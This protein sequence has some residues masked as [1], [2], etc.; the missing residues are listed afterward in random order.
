[1]K[2]NNLVFFIFI[3]CLMISIIISPAKFLSAGLNGISAWAFCVLPTVLPFMILSQLLLSTG[4]VE[5]ICK[6]LTTPFRKIYN[7]S[8][9]SPY[10]FLVSIVSGYPIGSKMIADLYEQGKISRTDVYRMS[11]FC[12]NSGPMFIIGAVGC[13]M[14]FSPNA[15]YIILISHILSAILN[16]LIYRKINAKDL[17]E[18]PLRQIDHKH[19]TFADIIEN[20]CKSILNVGTIIAFFFI[21]IEFTNQIIFF[22]PSPIQSLFF[23]IIEITKGCQSISQNFTIKMATI[24]STAVISFGGLS[25]IL[26]SITLLN[27]SK[28]SVWVFTLQK[29]TQSIIALCLS[30]ILSIF[31]L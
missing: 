5:K 14:L 28:M 24:L 23:G 7:T 8:S 26:Q 21:I 2:K 1:M 10:V 16:G 20:S 27:R 11:S 18:K 4:C 3:V 19:P 30:I 13:G 17:Q 22:L 6:P 9:Y 15:G 29:F 25:T 12:S 31:L